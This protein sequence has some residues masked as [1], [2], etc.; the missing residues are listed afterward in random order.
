[1]R[2]LLVEDYPPLR[3]S[4]A[5]MVFER[6]WRGDAARS[7]TG[8]RCGLGLSLVRKAVSVLGGSVDVS[9]RAGGQFGM[10]VSIPSLVAPARP[11]G[12]EAHAEE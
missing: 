7:A 3:T 5:A 10:A 1:M 4:V 11:D 6:F 9:S 12:S 8:D 2:V